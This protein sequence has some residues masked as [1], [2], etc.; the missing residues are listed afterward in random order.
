MW[1]AR[2]HPVLVPP[3]IIADDNV[4]PHTP[5]EEIEPEEPVEPEEPATASAGLSTEELIVLL[6]EVRR[7]IRD[8]GKALDILLGPGE[9]DD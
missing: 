1:W 3:P 9:S 7:L 4:V 5:T 6:K 2:H 8:L